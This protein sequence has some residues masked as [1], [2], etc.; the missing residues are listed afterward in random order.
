[1]ASTSAKHPMITAA[2]AAP[3]D[4]H[5]EVFQTEA[6][7]QVAEPFIYKTLPLTSPSYLI[8]RPNS[9]RYPYNTAIMT[10]RLT[11]ILKHITPGTGLSA[12]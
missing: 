10:E 7:M 11:S 6:V 1:M 8:S 9:Q 4:P 3:T 5:T 2:Y 12:M